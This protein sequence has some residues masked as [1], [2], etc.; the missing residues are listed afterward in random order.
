MIVP[1]SK[2]ALRI[3]LVA[4]AFT[5]VGAAQAAEKW[6]SI[7]IDFPGE[8]HSMVS[9]YYGIGGGDNKD[10]A[11]G[12][13]QKFCVEAGGKSCQTAV[14]YQ[15]CGAYAATEAH[16]GTGMADSKKRGEGVHREDIA[17]LT[18]AQLAH[19]RDT[20]DAGLHDMIR[21]H[22]EVRER[23]RSHGLDR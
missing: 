9:P 15:K 20:G 7:S 23:E 22:E 17:S 4:A 6:G 11:I 12:N 2:K 18:H 8:G 21:Q 14:N 1:T 16:G 5:M 13:A 10:E 3:G 19:L